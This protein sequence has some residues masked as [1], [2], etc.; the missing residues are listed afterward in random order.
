MSPFC[1]VTLGTKTFTTACSNGN[2]PKWN[3]E[4]R[5]DEL[6]SQTPPLLISVI[7]KAM[8][9]GS[10]EVGKCSV[11]L[12]LQSFESTKSF[13]LL[14]NSTPAESTGTI[15]VSVLIQD[16]TSRNFSNGEDLAAPLKSFSNPAYA[17][18]GRLPHSAGSFDD[19]KGKFAK[20]DENKAELM[21]MKRE[22]T[23][24]NDCLISPLYFFS[25]KKPQ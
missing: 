23:E 5:F 16:Q 1:Q 25:N 4:F 8:L 19:A 14:G 21:Y 24:Q 15:L 20:G 22:V 3:E 9:F 2:Q 11:K 18:Y 12:P 10:T 7:H 17:S 13:N 6:T